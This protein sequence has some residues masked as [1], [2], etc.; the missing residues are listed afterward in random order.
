MVQWMPLTPHFIVTQTKLLKGWRLP[1]KKDS[2]RK[3]E[4][5][6]YNEFPIL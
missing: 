4:Y 6:F 3:K 2:G 5:T 1:V